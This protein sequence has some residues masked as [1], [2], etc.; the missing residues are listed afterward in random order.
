MSPTPNWS[1]MMRK[2]PGQVVLH[3][4]LRAEAER[5]ADD[6]GARQQRADVDAEQRQDHEDRDR[7]HGDGDDAAQQGADGGGALLGALGQEQGRQLGGAG[8]LPHLCE[9]L[10][11][12]VLG[13]AADDAA[14]RARQHELHDERR[15]DDDEDCRGTP[16]RKS[17]AVSQNG[18]SLAAASTQ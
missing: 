15:D 17:R 12:R 8:H 14:D 16:I 1:S 5:D 3:E 9:A 10:A 18:A 7:P 4:R 6:A 11:L 13:R 2:M